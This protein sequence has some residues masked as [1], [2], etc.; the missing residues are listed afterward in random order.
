MAT[1]A[2]RSRQLAEEAYL[3]ADKTQL[4]GVVGDESFRAL[5]RQSHIVISG[6]DPV[7]GNGGDLRR[8]YDSIVEENPDLIFVALTPFGTYGP[9]SG[10]HGGDL[11]AQALSGWTWIV[12]MPGEAP[13]SMNFDMGALQQGL[14]AAGATLAALLERGSE[15]A[16]GEFVDISEADVIAACIRMY[17]LTYRFLNINLTRNGLRAPGSSGR[18]PHT[19][20][21]CKD[22]FIS[23]I[24]RS[25][26]DSWR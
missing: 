15:G 8:V 13:L 14:V 16:G 26:V 23:T 22:G 25:P 5:V 19:I 10:W 24:C 17:S 6:S 11:N 3:N 1:G 4:D 7:Q 18:Y 21:P 20:L 12:G 2:G 9:A